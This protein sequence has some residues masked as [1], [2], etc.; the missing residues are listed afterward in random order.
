MKKIITN[1]AE[2]VL[3]YLNNLTYNNFFNFL[4]KIKMLGAGQ[5]LASAAHALYY[6]VKHSIKP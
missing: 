6:S 2:Y 5:H 3:K 1:S 4:D